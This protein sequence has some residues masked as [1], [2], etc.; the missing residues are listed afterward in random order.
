ML[1]FLL[2]SA[3]LAQESEEQAA[4]KQLEALD[5]SGVEETIR[6]LDNEVGQ[7][8]PDLSLGGLVDAAQRGGL[9]ELFGELLTGIKGYL[10]HEVMA[11]LDLLGQLILLSVVAAVLNNLQA[12]FENSKT[13]RISSAVT[14]LVLITLALS[15][16]QHALGTA[17]GAIRQ[18]TD[19]VQAAMPVIITLIA[20]T[21]G[22]TTAAILHPLVVGA[23][24]VMGTLIQSLIFPLL[25]FSVVL[26]MVGLVSDR[27]QVEKLSGLFKEFGMLA[28]GVSMTIF[29]GILS[30]EGVAGSV[31]DGVAMRTAKFATGA[32]IPVVGKMMSDAL[33]AVVG[34]SLLLRNAIGLVGIILLGIIVVFPALKLLILVLVYR[35]AGALV[36]PFGDDK[37]PRALSAMSGSLSLVF[38][39]LMIMGLMFFLTLSILIG[40]GNFSVMLR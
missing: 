38:A 5:L 11:N 28:L 26:N 27:F 25:N 3:V 16:F 29:I 32:F 2:P 14:Y 18:M 8:L 13:A 10:F 33:E 17:S 12:A 30:I 20:S 1:I 22:M 24:G 7:Y 34:T 9:T 31:A 21:G 40:L 23:V 15:S 6:E 39:V 36:Q 37:M 19:L 35:V 4:A